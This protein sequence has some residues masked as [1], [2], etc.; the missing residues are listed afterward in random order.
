MLDLKLYADAK[1]K[2]TYL[3]AKDLLDKYLEI[4]LEDEDY[5]ELYTLFETEESSIIEKIYDR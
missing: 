3:Y 1:N 2:E 4:E 5:S